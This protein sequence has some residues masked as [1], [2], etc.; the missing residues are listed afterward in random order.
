MFVARRAQLSYG[1]GVR[2][3]VTIAL[4]AACADP[5][6]VA[7]DGAWTNATGNPD[8]G[9]LTSAMQ[10]P[11][12]FTIWQ[13]ADG[14]WHIWECIRFTLVGGNTRLFY[15]WQAAS[16][17]GPWTPDGIA[18]EADPSVGEIAGGLQAPYVFREADR[19]HMF[20]GAWE[21]ICSQ[22]SVDG[23]TFER[24][25]DASGQCPLFSEVDRRVRR[26]RGR[27]RQLG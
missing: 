18:M 23:L 15:R 10:Q 14:T 5:P 11:V 24:V 1:R 3:A 9:A 22:T 12:D 26:A 8:L 13:A 19:F 2:L 4:V 21:S 20:Y 25:L 7:I 6:S 27:R 16:P 17:L